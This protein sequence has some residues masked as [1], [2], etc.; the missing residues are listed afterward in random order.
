MP[1]FFNLFFSISFCSVLFLSFDVY[2]FS[3]PIKIKSYEKE[4]VNS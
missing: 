1:H 2:T 4:V 3:L